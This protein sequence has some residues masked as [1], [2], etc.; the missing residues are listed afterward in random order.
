MLTPL[1]SVLLLLGL[2]ITLFGAVRRVKLWHRGKPVA[3]N[4]WAGLS[5][6]PR[7]YLV[8]LHNVVARDKAT[9]H[10]HVAT[11]G[12]FVAALVMLSIIYLLGIDSGAMHLLALIACTVMLLG[13]QLVA[14]RRRSVPAHLST[15]PW[16]R[17]LKSLK[18]FAGTFLLVSIFGLFGIDNLPSILLVLLGVAMI[19]GMGEML[20]GLTWGGPMKHAFAGA[21]HLAFHPRAER[22]GG[23][24]STGLR[25]LDLTEPHLGVDK[26]TDFYWNQLL[27]FD[28]CV[29]CGRCEK[30]CPAFVA[31]QPLNPKKLIQDMVVGMTGGST[32]SYHGSAHPGHELHLGEKAICGGPEHSLFEGLL[33]PDTVWSCTTCRACVEECPMMIEHVDAIVDLRRYLTLEL[34]ATP[35]KGPDI[36]ENLIAT[37]NPNGH[38]PQQRNN[39]SV[40]LHIP[41][42]AEVKQADV[43]LW[44]GDG[45][46]DMRNQRTLR[47]LVTLLQRAKVDFA[48]L[49]NE[50]LDC[51][52]LARR[53]GDE[54]TFQRL[55]RA[56]IHTLSQYRFK[57]IVT[58]DPHAFQLLKNEYP[59]FGGHY[60]V[61]HHTQLLAELVAQGGLKLEPVQELSVTYHDPCYLGR[62]N[63]GYEAPRSLLRAIGIEIKEMERSGY[64]SRCCGGGGGAPVTDIA[65][66]RRIPDMR[67]DDVRETGAD[68]VV[69]A[70]PQCSLMLEGVI[71][72]RPEVRDIA[73]LL[74]EALPQQAR[75]L[76]VDEMEAS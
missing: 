59:D 64:R 47:A 29:Q 65:G 7:R 42:M 2:L 61:C 40:D 66:K 71:E 39:W 20:L 19:A 43:L 13:A 9:A 28:A 56:N 30:A 69:V 41:L 45:A 16:M 24:Q 75:Y 58:A 50:E 18:V 63:G 70:C 49:G 60:D 35:G 72:P 67:M 5:S 54:A 44:A 1:V 10:M 76:Q 62:Y 22:F 21:L 25:P 17:L 33:D 37:D 73:E 12:G 53:L 6:I 36:L 14:G 27:G 26:P 31:G 15:G 32:A 34:G 3:V 48:V 51:G 55:A 68:I 23:G 57:R 11:A 46:F 4:I 8:D 52:D 38:P 74:L